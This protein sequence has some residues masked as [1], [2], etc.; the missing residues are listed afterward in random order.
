MS[1]LSF[2]GSEE[3]VANVDEIIGD[4]AQTDEASHAICSPAA[5]ATDAMP[6]F[7]NADNPSSP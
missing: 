7:E 5:A 3:G 6:T 1:G 2:C 4:D